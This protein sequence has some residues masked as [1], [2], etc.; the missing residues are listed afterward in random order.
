MVWM[1]RVGR[2]PAGPVPRPAHLGDIAN[3][4][5]TGAVPGHRW[6]RAAANALPNGGPGAVGSLCFFLAAWTTEVGVAVAATV[7][8]TSPPVKPVAMIS[9][10][11]RRMV[12]LGFLT[13]SL[14][15]GC[16]RQG[17]ER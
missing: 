17:C 4:Q 11:V 15:P 3:R 7:T 5:G 8:R 12:G 16:A 1:A 13:A 14:H 10:A 6:A 2:T 9:T